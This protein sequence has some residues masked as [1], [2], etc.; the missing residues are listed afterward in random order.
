MGFAALLRRGGALNRL[1][2]LIMENTGMGPA[3]AEALAGALPGC[4]SLG[5]LDLSGNPLGDGGVRELA[6]ALP[7]CKL[8]SL[9]LVSPGVGDAGARA[10]AAALPLPRLGLLDARSALSAV[11]AEAVE[12]VREAWRGA[13]KDEAHLTI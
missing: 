5:C 4:L 7:R 2:S 1:S 13:G 3:D 12:A 8:Q 11:G 10:L 6:S 9:N